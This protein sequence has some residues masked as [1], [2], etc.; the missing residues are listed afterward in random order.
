M[1]GLF[2]GRPGMGCTGGAAWGLLFGGADS[3]DS[4][5]TDPSGVLSFDPEDRV[6]SKDVVA[7]L[8]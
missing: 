1:S 6:D 3:R 8:E 5:L 2:A 7:D 4:G